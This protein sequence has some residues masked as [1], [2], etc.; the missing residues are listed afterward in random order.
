MIP[1]SFL[2]G[3]VAAVFIWRGG[4]KTKRTKQVEERLRLALSMDQN[5]HVIVNSETPPDQNHAPNGSKVDAASGAAPAVLGSSPTWKES[6][7]EQARDSVVD[8]R[9]RQ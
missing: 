7:P 4:Q 3:I 9:Q 8:G 2:C 5:D 6:N 1:A